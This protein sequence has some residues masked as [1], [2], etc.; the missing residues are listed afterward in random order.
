MSFVIKNNKPRERETRTWVAFST[1]SYWFH[2]RQHILHTASCRCWDTLILLPALLCLSDCVCERLFRTAHC[3]KQSEVSPLHWEYFQFHCATY[4]K[5]LIT[6]LVCVSRA[7]CTASTSI[8]VVWIKSMKLAGEKIC[9][10]STLSRID[11]IGHGMKLE[12]I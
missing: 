12:S 6:Y 3:K 5:R 8:V 1:I 2:L 7:A 10:S 4:V 9:S 11:G